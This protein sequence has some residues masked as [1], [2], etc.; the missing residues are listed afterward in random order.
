MVL[1]DLETQVVFHHPKELTAVTAEEIT[2]VAEVAVAVPLEILV[3]MVPDL[4]T[5]VTAVMVQ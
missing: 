1:A 2:L 3:I 4:L 5:A